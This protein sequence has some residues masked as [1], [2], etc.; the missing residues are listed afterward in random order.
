MALN[1]GLTYAWKAEQRSPY[2]QKS[3]ALINRI[4]DTLSNKMVRKV[5]NRW[6]DEIWPWDREGYRRPSARFP[7]LMSRPPVT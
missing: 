2:A 7:Q 3:M 5:K 1:E 6:G 4:T